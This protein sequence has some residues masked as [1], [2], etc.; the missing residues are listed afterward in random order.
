MN[1]KD[2]Q[3]KVAA[4]A[5][6][7]HIE[8]GQIIGIG[9]GSTVEIF[10]ELLK[11]RILTDKLKIKT[12]PTSYQSLL[13]L[14]QNKIPITSLNEYP[15][16]DL[17]ID[18]ADEI[19]PK[20]DLIKGGGAA[21]TQEKIVDSAANK[22]IIISDES[23]RVNNLGE[24]F[25]VPIEIIPIALESVM[26]KLKPYSSDCILREAVKK[27]GPVVTDNG[28][29]IIDAKFAD[30][31]N[32]KQLELNLNGIPGIIENGLFIDMAEIVYIGTNSGVEKLT[33]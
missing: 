10:I 33:R 11:D 17:A 15:E 16:L 1:E 26:I 9:S 31:K 27:M 19:D 24:R 6:V 28:N 21:L 14:I 2:R 3:K 30:I 18:G 22:F 25:R 7:N 23:K 12:V 5:A 32:P 8:T 20:L 29:F 13:L 4:K